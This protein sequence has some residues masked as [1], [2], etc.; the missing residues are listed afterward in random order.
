M[1]N[2]ITF[3]KYILE[4][5]E[6]FEKYYNLL[7]KENEKYNLTNIVEREEAFIK[8][9]EDSICMN[10]II[11][12]NTV[13]SICDIGSGAGFPSLPLKIAYP[14]LKVTIIEPT[15]K[16]VNFMK[17]VVDMLNLKDV[18]V[19]NGRAEDVCK[20]DISH[21]EK[22]DVVTARALATLPMFLELTACYC[23]I[24]G[25][26]VA[27]K[28]SNFEEEIEM[29]KNALKILDLKV[30]KTES[31]ELKKDFGNRTLIKI[32]K[33]KSTNQKYPRRFAEIK[34]KLL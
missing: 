26:L 4:N 13:E 29:S 31:F 11:D 7:V 21:I 17:M 12:M 24:G 27:Y 34:R 3:N 15:L 25:S 28:G 33:I 32:K 6:S 30:E 9:F 18:N 8:H 1:E 19:I 23:K 14:H 20:E 10:R 22:Y 16:R 2:S 5:Y